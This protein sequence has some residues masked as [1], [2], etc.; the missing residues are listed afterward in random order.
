MKN[1]NR[2][3]TIPKT[4]IS[5]MNPTVIKKLNFRSGNK[6][7]S[8]M[9]LVSR[10]GITA[11]NNIAEVAT[12]R[13]ITTSFINPDENDPADTENGPMKKRMIKNKE[14]PKRIHEYLVFSLYWT[15]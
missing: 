8:I 11:W 15:I 12:S 4:A 9:P 10:T 3:T 13:P 5:R 1:Y 6:S 2:R 7:V 14:A